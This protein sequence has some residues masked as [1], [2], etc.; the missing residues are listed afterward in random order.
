MNSTTIKA[1][2]IF[3]SRYPLRH[4]KKGH[5]LIKPGEDI[6]YAH[7][8]VEGK[9]KVYDVSYRG[10]EIII[11]NRIPPAIFPMAFVL[12]SAPTRYVYEAS[13]DIAIRRAPTEDVRAYLDSHPKIVLELLANLYMIFDGVLERMVHYIT[14]NAKHRLIYTIISE[15]KEF[16]TLLEDDTYRIDVNETDLASRAGLSRETVSREAR[17]LKRARHLEVH[18]N[19]MIVRNI[20]ELEQYIRPTHNIQPRA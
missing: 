11:T 5:I 15:C 20:H 16:G 18:R 2:S 10:D 12:N 14:S 7:L 4:Y 19:F 13:T 1:L 6:R 17:S 9:V 3:F 8:L